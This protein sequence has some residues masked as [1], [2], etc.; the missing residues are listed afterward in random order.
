M[1]I[2][3]IGT[4]GRTYSTLQA[5]ENA[6]PANLVTS[7]D[8]WEGECYNDSEFTSTTNTLLIS[9]ITANA[10]YYV[11]LRCATGQS[12]RDNASV[13]SNALDYAQ[14]NGVAI[15]T[16]GNYYAAI[17]CRVNYTRFKDLQIKCDG[18]G[19]ASAIG[20]SIAND[21]VTVSNCIVKTARIGLS[22][23]SNG[24]GTYYNVLVIGSGAYD[25]FGLGRTGTQGA[26]AIGCTV[27]KTGTTGGTAFALGNYN[28]RTI[29]DCAGF[30]C[31]N[32]TTGTATDAGSSGYNCT[33]L[34]TAFG[35]T[36]NQVSKTF[37]NQFVSTTN[38]FR[39]LAGADLINNGTTNA[40]IDPD[41]SK[42][43]RSGTPTIGC[44][45]YVSAGGS[46]LP[47]F[48]QDDLMVGYM[49]SLSGGLQ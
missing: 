14:A 32:F 6:A 2:S 44:W 48:M 35:S 43:T 29:I 7:T 11:E 9:G 34:A 26:V 30:N 21:F 20:L 49:Q 4:T 22:G 46:G 10:T 13:R 39:V 18:A 31:T 33:D 41:I 19:N 47:F 42:T 15:R 5:W 38:D 45:E 27:V 16:S 28:T 8:T 12:F 25:L 40:N 24:N 3:S 37:A 1:T 17:D 36:G 23:A